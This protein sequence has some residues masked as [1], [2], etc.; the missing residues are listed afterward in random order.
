MTWQPS[1]TLERHM[2]IG[3]GTVLLIVVIVLLVMMMRGR[4]TV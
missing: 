1:P 3:V 2:Y 4:R